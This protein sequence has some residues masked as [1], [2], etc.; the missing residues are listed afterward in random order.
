MKKILVIGMTSNYAGTEGVIYNYYKNIDKSVIHFDFLT[1]SFSKLAYEDNMIA[2]GSKIYRITQ[3]KKNYFKY[4]KEMK[5]FFKNYAEEYDAIWLNTNHLYNIDYLIYGKKYCIKHRILHSHNS[6]DGKHRN[7]IWALY[8]ILRTRIN[9]IIQLNYATDYWAC[10]DVAAKFMF[11]RNRFRSGEYLLI[12][13][14]IEVLNYRFNLEDRERIRAQYKIKEERVIV[15]VGRFSKEKNHER[16]LMIFS[17][18]YKQNKNARLFLVGEGELKKEVMQRADHLPIKDS[19]LFLGHRNDIASIMSASD[20]FI[21]PSIYEGLPI[22]GIEAQT[23][24]LPCV[25]SDSISKEVDITK[26]N[27]FVDLKASDEEWVTAIES[28]TRADPDNSIAAI[29]EEGYDIRDVSQ[30]VEGKYLQSEDLE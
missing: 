19:V 13:N 6:N 10:S 25:F 27:A 28:V 5:K 16:L 24:G 4:K 8:A 2:N 21:L 3:K 12:H 29:L 20:V 11:S 23:N 22:V 7:I 14:G 18:Y 15:H 9:K 30:K 17:A 1:H 26:N